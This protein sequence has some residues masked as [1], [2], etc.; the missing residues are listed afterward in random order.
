MSNFKRAPTTL[1]SITCL[2]LALMKNA[3]VPSLTRARVGM[4]WRKRQR[5]CFERGKRVQTFWSRDKH[6]ISRDSTQISPKTPV[7]TT[8]PQTAPTDNPINAMH[9]PQFSPFKVWRWRTGGGVFWRC[10]RSVS[11]RLNFGQKWT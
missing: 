6:G 10:P 1:Y 7:L 9:Q 8:T 5:W 11:N 3:N 4:Y 2:F